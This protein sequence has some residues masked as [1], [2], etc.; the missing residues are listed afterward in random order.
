M[1]LIKQKT[2]FLLLTS[3]TI[4]F[5]SY[6]S[7]AADCYEFG[8]ETSSGGRPLKV[9]RTD[10]PYTAENCFNQISGWV[11]INPTEYALLKQIEEQN[12]TSELIK[13]TDAGI[14]F[15]FGLSAYLLFWFIGYKGRLAKQAIRLV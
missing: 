7:Q 3:L 4:A 12:E 10:T 13:S 6:T 15:T 14:A 5:Y 1:K 11:V 8:W 9:F 2:V